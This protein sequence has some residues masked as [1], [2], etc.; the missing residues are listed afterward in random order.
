MFFSQQHKSPYMTHD[1]LGD[2]IPRYRQQHAD[3]ACKI[4]DGEQEKNN[5]QRMD[6][7]FSPHHLR[8]NDLAFDLLGDDNDHDDQYGGCRRIKQTDDNA[9][10]RADPRADKGDDIGHHGDNTQ[11]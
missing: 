8:G 1:H 6:R 10:K 2:S 5:G 11:H 9:G 7:K 4:S 3:N